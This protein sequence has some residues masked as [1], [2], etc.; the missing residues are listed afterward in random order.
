M[1]RISSPET[2]ISGPL[3]MCSVD[4]FYKGFR[5]KVR[6][7]KPG[8]PGQSGSY[9]EALNISNHSLPARGTHLPFSRKSVVSITHQQTIICSKILIC[10]QLFFYVTW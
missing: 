1:G 9:E 3:H 4:R 2:V 10:G 8:Q 6:S 5:G 7:R